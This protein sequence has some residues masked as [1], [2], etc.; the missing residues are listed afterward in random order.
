MGVVLVD[1]Q[2]VGPSELPRDLSQVS[3]IVNGSD[4]KRPGW[5]QLEWIDTDGI[6]HVGHW[7]DGK[8]VRPEDM[9]DGYCTG[10]KAFGSCCNNGEGSFIFPMIPGEHRWD[11]GVRAALYLIGL[12]WVFLGV[13]V[14]CDAFMNGIEAITSQM[15]TKK[16]PMY[17]R[18]GHKKVDSATGAVMMTEVETEVWNSSVANLTLMALGSST[19]EILLSVIETCGSGFYSG[20]LGPGTVVGSAAFNL[21]LITALCIQAL[22]DGELRKI[23]KFNV[24]TL[25]A[26]HSVIAYAW[27]VIIVQFSSKNVVDVWEAAVTLGFMPYLTLFV[28]AADRNWFKSH[29]VFPAAEEGYEDEEGGEPRAATS[30]GVEMTQ[31]GKGGSTEGGGETGR[32]FDRASTG[33]KQVNPSRAQRRR[34]AMRFISAPQSVQT[35]HIARRQSTGGN[36]AEQPEIS[37]VSPKFQ[38]MENVGDATIGIKRSGP[39]SFPVTI[40]WHTVDGSAK[41][42]EDYEEGSGK[43]EFEEGC[44]YKEITVSILEDD[45]WNEDKDFTVNLKME[46]ST[47]AVKLSLAKTTVTIIDIDHPGEFCFNESTYVFMSSDSKAILAIER[48]LGSAGIATVKFQT[49]DGG[50]A[51]AGKQYEAVDQVITFQP[52]QAAAFVTI[53]LKSEGWG[54]EGEDAPTTMRFFAELSEPTPSG[55]ATLGKLTRVEVLIRRKDGGDGGDGEEEDVTWGG[56]FR[57]AMTAENPK[58]ASPGELAM[59]YITVVWKLLAACVPPASYYNGKATFIVALGLIGLVTTF[60]NDLASIF[61]CLVDLEDSVNAI[62]L[63]ALGTSLPD[64]FASMMAA[65]SDTNA[66]NSIGNVTGSN[67]VNVFLGIGLPWFLAACYWEA[68]K[69]AGNEVT[70]AAWATKITRQYPIEGP[71]I[72]AQYP[73]GAFVVVGGS[74]AFNTLVFTILALVCLTFLYVRRVTLGGELG[75]PKNLQLMSSAFLVTLW[76]IYILVSSLQVYHPDQFPDLSAL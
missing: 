68:F 26:V 13:S 41:A 4:P 54:D 51:T 71:D 59:H 67:S 15:R 14:L 1:G 11:R 50:T 39:V 38:F 7:V 20:K 69:G 60:I 56:Q 25:T 32:S 70:N 23:E 27:L 31:N 57:L 49:L 8:V 21:L 3:R 22:P 12:F 53:P 43:V 35:Q 2:A 64:T 74:L 18:N 16:V 76:V 61:G 29:Q 72:V 28:W 55:G 37:F 17:D 34:E 73:T 52:D 65:K 5:A 33:V 40:S 42:G 45:Q 19:P 62:T 24:Y 36:E 63:V 10:Q 66:D 75:G 46:S 6:T 47:D 44:H 30:G 9:P 48:R 58:E